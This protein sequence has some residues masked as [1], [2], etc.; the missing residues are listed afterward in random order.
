MEGFFF[1]ILLQITP[2]TDKN[3]TAVLQASYTE[4]L[5]SLWLGISIAVAQIAAI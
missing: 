5:F 4:P 1:A 2:L 3:I